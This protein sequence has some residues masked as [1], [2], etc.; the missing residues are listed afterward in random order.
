MKRGTGSDD[1]GDFVTFQF[2]KVQTAEEADDFVATMLAQIKA[3]EVNPVRIA[4]HDYRAPVCR[5]L[6]GNRSPSESDHKC[7]RADAIDETMR[8]LRSTMAA[9]VT[10]QNTLGPGELSDELIEFEA[11]H[12]YKYLLWP[13]PAPADERERLLWDTCRKVVR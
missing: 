5:D 12:Q 7:I 1:R 13:V 3:G 4:Q 11:H 8:R 2:A 6:A 9:Q 10:L